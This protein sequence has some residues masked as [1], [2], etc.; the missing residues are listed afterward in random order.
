[1]FLNYYFAILSLACTSS[2]FTDLHLF[3]FI[4][5]CHNSAFL[6][7]ICFAMFP[8][9]GAFAVS[10]PVI[11]MGPSNQS[12]GQIRPSLRRSSAQND[13]NSSTEPMWKNYALTAVISRT[14]WMSLSDWRNG[15]LVGRQRRLFGLL[16][17]IG[18]CT[19]SEKKKLNNYPSQ[20]VI[21]MKNWNMI[22]LYH[23]RYSHTDRFVDTV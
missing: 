23:G 8:A 19:R 18:F 11:E 22:K 4:V 10:D 7:R 16:T 3:S 17:Y 5:V 2:T 1:V 20:S 13:Y 14:T 9:N 6:E 15:K 21:K 12:V